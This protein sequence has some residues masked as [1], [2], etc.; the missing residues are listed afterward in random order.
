MYTHAAAYRLYCVHIIVYLVPMGT[1]VF[2]GFN[3]NKRRREEEKKVQL[4]CT[5]Q[6]STNYIWPSK[7]DMYVIS[8]VCM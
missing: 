8:I 7:Q 6:V 3:E 5:D 2:L 4:V 1:Q